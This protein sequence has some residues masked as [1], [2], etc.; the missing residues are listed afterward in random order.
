MSDILDSVSDV[1]I[2]RFLDMVNDFFF[3]IVV[4]IVFVLIRQNLKVWLFFATF[5]T[6]N[7]YGVKFGL[8]F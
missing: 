6:F 4:H 8:G 5:I 7:V 3:Q 1:S 2:K